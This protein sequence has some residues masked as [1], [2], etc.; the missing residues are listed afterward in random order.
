MITLRIL[1]IGGG[2]I[3]KELLNRMNLKQHEIIIVE[4]DQNKCSEIGEKYDVLIINKDA[5]DIS[6]YTKDIDMTA[7]DALLALTDKDEVNV[8]ILTIAKIYNVPF[9][10][11]RVRS[12][13]MAELITKLDLGFPITIPSIIGDIVKNFLDSLKEAK[14]IT[15]LGN[16]KLYWIT[17]TSADK[18]IG[19]RIDELELP[20]DVKILLMFDGNSIRTPSPEETLNNGYQ[21]LVMTEYTDITDIIRLLKG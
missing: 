17:L 16:I 6:I 8:L 10:L 21:L 19:K 5:T 9:R 4:K 14:L 12:N 13:N 20:T 11:A 1:I 18:A 2:S 7:V 3:T 15:I